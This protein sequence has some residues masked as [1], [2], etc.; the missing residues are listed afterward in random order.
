MDSTPSLSV[1]LSALADPS[2]RKVVTQLAL[3]A[4]GVEHPC[5]SFDLP[6]SKATRTHHFKVL[7]EAGLIDQRQHGNGSSVS[8]RR[9]YVERHWPGLLT[10]LT[11]EAEAEKVTV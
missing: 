5:G 8:L 10:L 1:V 7:R 3:D 6:V 4:D 2:R 9:A 11:R